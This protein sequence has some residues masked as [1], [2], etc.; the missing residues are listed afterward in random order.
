MAGVEGGFLMSDTRKDVISSLIFFLM[1]VGVLIS[2]TFIKDPGLSEMGPREF[3]EFIGACMIVLSV[4][5]FGKTAYEYRKRRQACITEC[6]ES[7]GQEQ[8]DGTKNE[9]RALAIAGV[10]LLY[11]VTFSALGYFISTFLAITLICLLFREKRIWV[12]P[13][14]YVVAVIIWMGFNYLLSIRLP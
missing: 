3:P 5:L 10:C 1:G 13:L 2:T 9:L 12:Y 11:A 4:A 6:A 8:K 7:D 14:L